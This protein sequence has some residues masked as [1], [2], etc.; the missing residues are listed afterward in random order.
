MKTA[1]T[2]RGIVC[3]VLP[4]NQFRVELH[5]SNREVICYLGGKMKLHKIRVLVG[6]NVDLVL[7]PYGGKATNRIT[8][9]L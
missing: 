5:G 9:R 4:N 7:G 1:A 2:T 3:E 6:D 8:K